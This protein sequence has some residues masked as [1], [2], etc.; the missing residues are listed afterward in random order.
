M[1]FAAAVLSFGEAFNTTTLSIFAVPIKQR[2]GINNEDLGLLFGT[3]K[4]MCVVSP[5]LAG[6]AIRR[7][8]TQAVFVIGAC[9]CTKPNPLA[10]DADLEIYLLL[11]SRFLS[12]AY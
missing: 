3:R 12:R 11:F 10:R 2:Y 6:I 8:G 4:A 9:A 1:L 7:F 5:I